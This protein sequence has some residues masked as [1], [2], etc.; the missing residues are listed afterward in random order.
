MH[1][2]EQFPKQLLIITRILSST[3]TVIFYE[4]FFSNIVWSYPNNCEI[5]SKEIN[6]N[7]INY[8]M[9]YYKKNYNSNSKITC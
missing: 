4:I 1:S 6:I 8:Y 2:N 9:L 3:D 7:A 5:I